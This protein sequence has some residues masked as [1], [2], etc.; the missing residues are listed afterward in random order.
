MKI[1]VNTL[2]LAL[3]SGL[4]GG[5]AARGKSTEMQSKPGHSS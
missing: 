2:K 1:E 4:E 3:F 5:D